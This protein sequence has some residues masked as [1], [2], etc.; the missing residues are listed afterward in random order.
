MSPVILCGGAAADSLLEDLAD[1][2]VDVDA[3]GTTNRELVDCDS[4]NDLYVLVVV[5]CDNLGTFDI[6]FTNE[7]DDED[8]LSREYDCRGNAASATISATPSTVEIIPQVN[9]TDESLIEVVIL[10]SNGAAAFPGDE[11]LFLT[12]N[13]GFSANSGK[14]SINDDSTYDSAADETTASA[15]LDCSDPTTATPGPATVTAIVEKSG[16]DIVISTVV[17]VVGPPV[18]NGLTVVASPEDGLICGEKAT[19]IITVVDAIG[20]NVSDHTR[21]EVITNFGGVLAAPGAVAGALGLVTPLSSTVVET[22]AG[23]A[24]VFLITSDTH[25]GNYEVLVTTG[26]HIS[27]GGPEGAVYGP[28]FSTQVTVTCSEAAPAPEIIAPSTG[29]GITP[30]STGDAGLR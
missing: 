1:V 22:F 24:E 7:M 5:V 25:V 30:P 4:D 26:G 16:S 3:A 15:L 2:G 8:T 10:D 13:C 14:D 12:D 21:V 28:P 27:A 6:A 11:V 17:T 20:Q 9:N 23:T 19:I 29:G 18:A